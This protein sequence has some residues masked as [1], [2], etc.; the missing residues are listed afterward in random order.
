MWT[1]PR[2]APALLA[3]ALGVPCHAGPSEAGGDGKVLQESLTLFLLR[4]QTAV[5]EIRAKRA[6]GGADAESFSRLSRCVTNHLANKNEA[7]KKAAELAANVDQ[8]L[9]LK[10]P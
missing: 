8:H 6:A 10:H 1:M 2:L 7:A 5:E 3:L 9:C 4:P